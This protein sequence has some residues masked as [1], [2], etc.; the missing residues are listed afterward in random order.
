MLEDFLV[1]LGAQE[2]TEM[3]IY[4]HWSTVRRGVGLGNPLTLLEAVG[5]D[6]KA[7][8]QAMLRQ[9]RFALERWAEFLAATGNADVGEL[10]TTHVAVW[11]KAQKKAGR[12]GRG[13]QRKVVKVG[14][15]TAQW[16]ALRAHVHET[17]SGA[18]AVVVQ[19]MLRTGLRISDIMKIQRRAVEE[20][21]RGGEMRLFLKGEKD[22]PYSI[23][24][25]QAQL[26]ELLTYK[27][28]DQVYQLVTR[29]N[30]VAGGQ[31][32]RRR[33]KEWAAEIGIE[34]VYPHKIRRTT[35]T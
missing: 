30:V 14:M 3:S 11:V 26:E 15:P 7:R 9:A 5:P 1:Y 33:L 4:K 27:D 29:G 20:G 13:R 17:K 10:V 19:I 16:R 24:P 23:V 35:I 21:L 22:Y 18:V 12:G 28:W 25:I 2:Y 8:T 34:D 31:A 6:G 32:V